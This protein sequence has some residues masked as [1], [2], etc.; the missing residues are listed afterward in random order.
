MAWPAGVQGELK[1]RC[2]AEGRS[3][4][5]KLPGKKWSILARPRAQKIAGPNFCAR[6]SPPLEAPISCTSGIPVEPPPHPVRHSAKPA[7][8]ATSSAPGVPPRAEICL[9]GSS[10]GGPRAP[11]AACARAA[12]VA[13]GAWRTLGGVQGARGTRGRGWAA[14]GGHAHLT[15]RPC[16]AFWVLEWLIYGKLLQPPPGCSST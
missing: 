9:Q 16:L 4:V 13:R 10:K 2:G 3:G 6:F 8:P 14:R 1:G 12:P 5:P 11:A 15:N 7:G